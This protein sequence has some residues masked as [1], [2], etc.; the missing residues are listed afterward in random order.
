VLDRFD[1]GFRKMEATCAMHSEFA[2]AEIDP[3]HLLADPPE[4]PTEVVNLLLAGASSGRFTYEPG[5]SPQR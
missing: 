1:H 5:R 2:C 3:R 4:D